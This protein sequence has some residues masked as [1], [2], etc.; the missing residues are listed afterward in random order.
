MPLKILVIDDATFIRDLVKKQLR[1]QLPEAEVY[2]AIDGAR[3][4]AIIKHNPIDLIL[5]DWEMPVMSGEELLR[6][7]RAAPES[8][9]T[10]FVMIT[11]RGDRD[12]I[13]K[14]IQ[15]GVSDYLAKPFTTV[16]LL[17]KV[18]KQLKHIGKMPSGQMPQNVL[19]SSSVEVLTGSPAKPAVQTAAPASASVAALTGGAA[20]KSAP[21]PAAQTAAVKHSAKARAQLRF[22]DNQVFACVVREMT[23]QMMGCVM[24]RSENL[25]RVFDQAVVDIDMEE[26][27][28]ARVNGYV[29]SVTAGENKPDSNVVK[30]VIRFVDNDVDKFEV[31]SK[32]IEQL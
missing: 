30:L 25:P 21:A 22:A 23:L 3:A 17:N 11:S 15:S 14:A 5:S 26:K 8:A 32:F 6:H 4:L 18:F 16:E 13:V 31:L 29:H 2:E 19:Q 24:Q 27:G 28:L 7:V 10:P 20:V 9:K 1:D 12:H